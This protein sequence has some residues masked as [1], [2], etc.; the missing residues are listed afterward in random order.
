MMLALPLLF[1]SCQKEDQNGYVSVKIEFS[2]L[3]I[4]L[5]MSGTA[6]ATEIESR[7]YTSTS[8]V[9]VEELIGTNYHIY[10]DRLQI[11]S[12]LFI[13]K[14]IND[15]MT[16]SQFVFITTADG[17]VAYVQSAQESM[18][19]GPST[20]TATLSRYVN[21]ERNM[22]SN[23]TLVLSKG[24]IA[25]GEDRNQPFDN[26]NYTD[27][28]VMETAMSTITEHHYIE[29]AWADEYTTLTAGSAVGYTNEGQNEN[30][31]LRYQLTT[32]ALGNNA[33]MSQIYEEQMN[34]K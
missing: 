22:L 16:F 3:N 34:T 28:S 21:Q 23:E 18:V 10:I 4:W 14:K 33:L 8:A 27:W 25:T 2:Q 13:Y 5:G 29:M 12:R 7:G 26:T 19:S 31:D 6:L 32:I 17:T 15:N 24:N 1:C 30:D 11:G 20:A 9:E